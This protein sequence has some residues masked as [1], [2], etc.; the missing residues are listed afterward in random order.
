MSRRFAYPQPAHQNPDVPRASRLVTTTILRER[1]LQLCVPDRAVRESL[2]LAIPC[3]RYRGPFPVHLAATCLVLRAKPAQSPTAASCRGKMFGQPRLSVSSSQSLRVIPPHAFWVVR[4]PIILQKAVNSLPRSALRRSSRRGR[5]TQLP[6]LPRAPI[7]ES[8][9]LRA[10]A[11][12]A[13][14]RLEAA[15][16]FPSHSFRS[17]Q[18]TRRRQFPYRAVAAHK[19]IHISFRLF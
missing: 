2:Q 11:A 8:S 10:L 9:I 16:S 12:S 18:R 3:C 1:S 4:F 6:A 14:T 19:P 17:R 7:P 15:S 13:A 5:R